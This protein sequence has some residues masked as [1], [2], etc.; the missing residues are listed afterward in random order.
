M[1]DYTINLTQNGS[2]I[3]TRETDRYQDIGG[4]DG[5]YRQAL[6]FWFDHAAANDGA[7]TDGYFLTAEACGKA[8]F[9]GVTAS[10]K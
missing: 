1:A 3:F 6:L 5:L 8:S 10:S 7:L 2:P 9:R 4:F